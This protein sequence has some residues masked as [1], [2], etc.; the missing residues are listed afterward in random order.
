MLVKCDYHRLQADTVQRLIDHC[1]AHYSKAGRLYEEILGWARTEW[2]RHRLEA[3]GEV[4]EIEMLQ[5]NPTTW[6]NRQ[7]ADALQQTE[8]MATSMNDT[9]VG[10]LVDYLHRVFVCAAASRLKK[11]THVDH[12]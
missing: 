9:A 8:C 6:T 11:E 2:R 12:P 10:K 5:I 4:R 7:V 3:V 1:M